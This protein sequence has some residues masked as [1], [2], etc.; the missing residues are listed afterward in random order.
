MSVRS[1]SGVDATIECDTVIEAM[2]MLANTSIL[3]EVSGVEVHAIV[4]CTEP[5][6]IAE[7]VT[8]DNLAGRHL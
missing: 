8:A 7:A 4:G 2:N 1:E 6:K 5:W 3:D